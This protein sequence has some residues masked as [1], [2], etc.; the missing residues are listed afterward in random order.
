MKRAFLSP[1]I[2]IIFII[3]RWYSKNMRSMIKNRKVVAWNGNPP[4]HR[5]C[6]AVKTGR[7]EE[8][9]RGLLPDVSNGIRL[10]PSL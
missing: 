9:K 4:L 3:D 7:R 5:N 8:G 10:L 2:I 6:S 1:D